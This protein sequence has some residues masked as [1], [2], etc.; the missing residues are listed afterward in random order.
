[1][2]SHKSALTNDRVPKNATVKKSMD[3]LIPQMEQLHKGKKIS[4]EQDLLDFLQ[5]STLIGLL[6]QRP[7]VE[8][9]PFSK[10]QGECRKWTKEYVAG[11]LVE[12][13]EPDLPNLFVNVEA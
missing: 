3:V 2:I 1:M 9:L 8:L 6:P 13:F 12:S 11:F 10:D 4:H 7:T 5:N